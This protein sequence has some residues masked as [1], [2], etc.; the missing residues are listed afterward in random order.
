MLFT[1][2]FGDILW[3]RLT[4]TTFPR[5]IKAFENENHTRDNKVELKCWKTT[6][7]LFQLTGTFVSNHTECVREITNI[8]ENENKELKHHPRIKAMR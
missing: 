8:F 6:F 2:Q 3:Q 4:R 1:Q 7:D 5:L